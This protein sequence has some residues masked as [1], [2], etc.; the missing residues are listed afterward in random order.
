MTV[1][2]IYEYTDTGVLHEQF[3]PPVFVDDHHLRTYIAFCMLIWYG[4]RTVVPVRTVQ[5]I[6]RHVSVVGRQ[7]FA[8]FEF[9]NSGKSKL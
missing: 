8:L 1:P 5:I 7:Q 3:N 4:Y 9:K 2:L 6:F